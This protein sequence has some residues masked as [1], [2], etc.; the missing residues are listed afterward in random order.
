MTS[1]T[2]IAI[3]AFVGGVVA[4][5][6]AAVVTRP[7][8]QS[9]LVTGIG[10]VFIKARDPE[11]LREWYRRHLGLE[12]GPQGLDF[13]WRDHGDPDRVA[14]TVW[15][16]FPQTTSHFGSSEQ[17]FMVNYRVPDL[18]VVLSHLRQLGVQP[19]RGPEDYSHG[20]FAWI[21]DGEGNRLEL[22]QPP[23]TE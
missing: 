14:R 16:L 23:P 5:T 12:T 8:Q 7:P 19:V 9:T 2:P 11:R 18:D 6:S 1:R 17:Q 15:N 20:R 22:W 21:V 10:G 3:L 13:R 4:G